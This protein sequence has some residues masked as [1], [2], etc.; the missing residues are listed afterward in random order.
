MTNHLAAQLYSKAA[1]DSQPS[2]HQTLI[3]YNFADRNG[4][5]ATT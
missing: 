2:T 4:G 5:E 1:A 3:H